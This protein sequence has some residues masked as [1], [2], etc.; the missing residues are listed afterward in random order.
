MIEQCIFQTKPDRKF[1]MN[2][3]IYFKAL[4]VIAAAFVF[5]LETVQSR[6]K[7]F[8]CLFLGRESNALGDPAAHDSRMSGLIRFSS[9]ALQYP[10]P[11]FFDILAEWLLK[12]VKLVKYITLIAAEI[13]NGYLLRPQEYEM[14]RFLKSS[15]HQNFDKLLEYLH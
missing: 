12:D 11:S 14:V 15:L 2:P 1:P 5:D 3:L 4:N 13:C 8:T 6:R 7:F 9:V 10:M